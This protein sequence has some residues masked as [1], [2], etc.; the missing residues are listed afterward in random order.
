MA[1]PKDGAVVTLSRSKLLVALEQM[2]AIAR[3]HS[4]DEMLNCLRLIV[5]DEQLSIQGTNRYQTICLDVQGAV[6]AGACDVVIDT[7]T[8]QQ[9]VKL[10]P[11]ADGEVK[12]S[13]GKQEAKIVQGP[14]RSKVPVLSSADY[15]TLLRVRKFEPVEVVRTAEFI[16]TLETLEKFIP[17]PDERPH[18]A[19]VRLEIMDGELVCVASNNGSLSYRTVPIQNGIGY[20]PDQQELWACTLPLDSFRPLIGLLE[21]AGEPTFEM[22]LD[23]SALEIRSGHSVFVSAIIAEKYPDWRRAIP[24]NWDYCAILDR[25]VV[26]PI[27]K[28]LAA[29]LSG[30]SDPCHVLLRLR[31]GQ[32]ECVV[33]GERSQSEDVFAFPVEG[34]APTE[35]TYQAGT[36]ADAFESIHTDKIAWRGMRDPLDPICLLAVDEQGPLATIFTVVMPYRVL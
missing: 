33:G 16:E 35:V 13:I 22:A 2:V 21:Q 9:I 23:A 6:A 14:R 29:S 32:A 19:G 15:P 17:S 24:E 34:T 26:S 25:Q 31:D 27:L 10:L 7:K 8:F 5:A 3:R 28:A 4:P 30:P 12:I 20:G 1:N 36:L 18:M 11:Q